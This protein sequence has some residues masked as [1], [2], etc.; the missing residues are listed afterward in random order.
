M[1][2]S[3][4]LLICNV[5]MRPANSPVYPKPSNTHGLLWCQR[6]T[7][8][9]L[10]VCLQFHLHT[11]ACI[12]SGSVGLSI[13]KG[14]YSNI[15]NFLVV[16][17]ELHQVVQVPETIS[18]SP[19]LDG[20]ATLHLILQLPSNSR[21]SAFLLVQCVRNP[22]GRVINKDSFLQ[23]FS[24][25]LIGIPL[26]AGWTKTKTCLQLVFSNPHYPHSLS[27]QLLLPCL[28]EVCPRSL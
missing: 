9:R 4:A 27:D 8:L 24:T 16:R 6:L 20:P 18:S 17:Q 2:I 10:T 23:H 28:F 21:K 22:N 25:L 3:S 26:V 19:P 12:R 13:T 1:G 7:L 14:G 5:N 15:A 11:S